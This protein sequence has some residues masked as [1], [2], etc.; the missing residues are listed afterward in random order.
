MTGSPPVSQ[1]L[2]A[3]LQSMGAVRESS[4]RATLPRAGLR[5]GA[6]PGAHDPVTRQRRSGVSLYARVVAVNAAVMSVA[7]LL[8]VASPATVSS[9]VGVDEGLILAGGLIAMIIANAIL[10]RRSFRGLEGLAE[11]MESLDLLQPPR[12]VEPMGGREVRTLIGAFNEMLGKLEAERRTSTHRTVSAL[13]E[14]RR[15]IGQEL[16]D[17]IGQRLTGILLQL[18]RVATDVPEQIRDRVAAIQ[19]ESRATLD[20]V[21]AL[22]WQ[23]RPGILEDLGLVSALQA[24]AQ[25]LDEHAGA[26]IRSDLPERVD[27]MPTEIELAVYRI[28]QE[29]LSNALRHSNGRRITVRL[30]GNDAGVQLSV[31][32]DGQGLDPSSPEGPG[33]RGMRERALLIGARLTITAPSAG[34]TTVLLDAP[35]TACGP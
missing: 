20:E 29:A 3:N 24:L 26:N 25:S 19:E 30:R 23:I 17:E 31:S 35:Y 12:R 11:H 5:S 21:G 16:H 32:D 28:A 10:L 34:G 2:N 13:E 14:E 6:P 7:A 15:R 27:Q 9:P 1:Q 8:L 22:A 18:G 4:R 33:I